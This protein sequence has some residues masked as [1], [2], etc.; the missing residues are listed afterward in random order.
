MDPDAATLRTLTT[1]D[2][3]AQWAALEGAQ[4]DDD[5]PRRS[6]LRLLGF[7]GTEHPRFVGIQ[8]EADFNTVLA[9]WRIP[10]PA[11]GG[12]GAAPAPAAPTFAQLGQAGIFART[13]RVIVGTQASTAPTP[14]A[15]PVPPAPTVAS[16]KIK[17]AQVINQTDEEEIE[18]LDQAAVNQAYAVYQMKTGGFPPEDEELSA[19]QLTT[20]DSLFKAGRVPYTD[21]AI[22]GPYHVRLV[23][24]IKMK[25]VRLTPTGEL[26]TVEMFGPGD[27]ETWRSCYLI[28]RTG[29]IM[30]DQ[31]STSALD[32]YEKKIRRYH[33]R[34]GRAC[35]PL[36]YQADVRARLEHAERLRRKGHDAHEKAL[37]AGGITDYDPAKPWEWVWNQLAQEPDF[38]HR[39]VEEPCILL[40]AKTQNL[41]SL[42]GEDATVEPSA[43][44]H[45]SSVKRPPPPPPRDESAM[46]ASASGKRQR[47]PDI[48]EHRLGEDG[49]FSHN[50]KGIELCRLWQTGECTDTDR[51]GCCAKYPQRRHQCSKCLSDSHGAHKCP[52]E[53]APKPPRVNH[54]KGKGKKGKR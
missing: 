51:R 17:M 22:W 39:E 28:F 36:I 42:I 6:L 8:T 52:M 12:G 14:A 50:R 35:W 3:V 47:G 13:C 33:E 18:P 41:G 21:M 4:D 19:E 37:R 24:K 48:R 32:N 23:K 2:Q 30:L 20:L 45:T 5:T 1:L 27:Y 7:L 49:N 46:P 31:I 11:P 16:R 40:L 38:W 10:Q 43:A 26:T 9:A 44:R 34:Y 15:P 29:C 54:G 25:G 53:G